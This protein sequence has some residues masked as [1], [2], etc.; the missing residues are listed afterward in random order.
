MSVNPSRGDSG[1]AWYT[2]EGLAVSAFV[3][4]ILAL[5]ALVVAP[6]LLLRRINRMNDEVTTTILPAY[7]GLRDLV[8]AMEERI[9]LARTLT[10]TGDPIYA[11]RLADAKVAEAA[12]LRTLELLAPRVGA[13]SAAA[14]E[15]LR[16]HMAR[17]D[18]LESVL[19]RSR[20]GIDQ[21]RVALPRFNALRDS[22]LA[23]LAV[24]REELVRVTEAG[25]NEDARWAKLQNSISVAL[26]TIAMLAAMLVGWFAW[27]QRRLR[28]EIQS[29]LEEANRLRVLAEQRQAELER[30]TES[31]VRLLRGV[32]HDV[33]NPL[34]AA[35]GYAE[36]LAMGIKGPLIPEQ[37]PMVQGIQRSIDG[38]L[39]ILG[40]LLDLVRAESGGLPI[41][42]EPV[43]LANVVS[44]AVE[45]HRAAAQSAQHVLEQESPARPVHVLT[46][47]ARV[48]QVLDNLLSNAL[49][50]TPAPGRITVRA[51]MVDGA[52]ARGRPACARIEVSDTGPGIPPEMREA[53]FDEFTRIDE[54]APQKG[55]GLGLAIARRIARLLGGDLTVAD[56]D[57]PGAT[58]LLWLPCDDSARAREQ[59]R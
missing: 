31:R 34:G 39:A 45:D 22:M 37:A 4:V 53:I 25:I 58:F 2:H 46:D 57:G 47:P 28:R 36:I 59:P 15:S 5:I 24:L 44:E 50:Y 17:R 48:R 42:R 54:G 14:I 16:R 35:K 52:E 10:F 8:V 13:A 41:H 18:S 51:E 55:H 26:G 32:T 12:T 56:R 9:V 7:G 27:R 6:A 1:A 33:K 23:Q 20:A 21:H 49:K 38:A 30:V 29:A 19:M 43:D 40:D 3:F 11:T